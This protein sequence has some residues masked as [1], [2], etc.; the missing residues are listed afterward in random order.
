MGKAVVARELRRETKRTLGN[1]LKEFA[2]DQHQKLETTIVR[3]DVAE[4]R[5]ERVVQRLQDERQARTY[6]DACL[7]A[8]DAHFEAMTF[9]QRLR[10]LLT[11]ASPAFAFTWEPES[12]AQVEEFWKDLGRPAA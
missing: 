11:G 7:A 2:H 5:L 8:R 3:L 6:Q 1:Q 12:S 10:W 4:A 9:W